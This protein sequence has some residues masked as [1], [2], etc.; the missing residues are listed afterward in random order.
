MSKMSSKKDNKPK[1]IFEHFEEAAEDNKGLMAVIILILLA[2]CAFLGYKF[3]KC[4]PYLKTLSGTA[5]PVAVADSKAFK[6]FTSSTSPGF[7]LT[8]T[9]NM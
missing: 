4:Q 9:P 5:S 8:Y 7:D 3:Y 6:Y 1:S 2:V